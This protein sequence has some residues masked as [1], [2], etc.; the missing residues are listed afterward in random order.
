MSLT[1]T[2]PATT[3]LQKSGSGTVDRA[4]ALTPGPTYELQI[5]GAAVAEAAGS[6]GDCG[7]GPT[8]SENFDVVFS[9]AAAP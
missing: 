6:A 9:F 3:L 5:Q 4:I 2:F 7:C 1:S 8:G